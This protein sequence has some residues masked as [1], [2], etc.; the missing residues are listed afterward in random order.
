MPMQNELLLLDTHCWLWAQ[1]G[2]V[3]RLSRR[4]VAAMRNA[5]SAGNLRVSVISVWELGMLEERGRVALP[6]NI[7]NW[8]EEALIK[9]GISL[10]PLTTEIAI[11]S[12]NLPGN[13]HGDPADRIIVATARAW[14]ATLLTKDE[15]LIDYS[16]Q[17][18]VRVLEA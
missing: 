10:A 6:M 2:Q 4:A 15:R 3:D 18:H 5:E 12:S 17:R 9:P 14:N 13:L 16:R 1:L 7:R 8:V 11:E